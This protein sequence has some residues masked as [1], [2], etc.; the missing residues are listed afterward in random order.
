MFQ[1]P[2][3][4][5]AQMAET[6]TTSGSSAD[7]DVRAD[8]LRAAEKPTHTLAKRGSGQELQRVRFA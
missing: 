5:G 6:R 8:V 4:K 1:Y 7:P 2:K 3:A